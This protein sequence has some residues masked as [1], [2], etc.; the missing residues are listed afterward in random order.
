MSQSAASD[1]LRTLENH[2]EVALFDRVSNRLVLSAVGHSLRTE[3]EK[4]LSQCRDF[5]SRLTGHEELGHLQVGASFTIGNHLATRYLTGYLDQYPDAKVQ[6]T[7]ANTPE[8]VTRVLNFEV[9][10]G[11]IEA[12]AHHSEL[13]FIPWREDELRVFC[14]AHHPLAQKRNFR[15]PDL[16]SDIMHHSFRL[17][18]RSGA[19]RTPCAV[20]FRVDCPGLGEFLKQP[21]ECRIARGARRPKDAYPQDAVLRFRDDICR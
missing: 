5:E 11:M 6:L 17:C 16:R 21:G 12:E 13:D 15:C 18:S 14:A 20:R 7:T 3:A 1:A 19:V 9:D 10:I 8:I 2:Y 4:L